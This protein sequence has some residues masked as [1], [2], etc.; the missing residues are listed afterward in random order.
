MAGLSWGLPGS[1]IPKDSL[2]MREL[3]EP[4]FPERESWEDRE[5]NTHIKKHGYLLLGVKIIILLPA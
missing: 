5:L 1:R 2:W 4:L 3:Y